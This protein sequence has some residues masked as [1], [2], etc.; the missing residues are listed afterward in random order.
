MA[1]NLDTHNRAL[2]VNLDS[3]VF[4]TV[5]RLYAGLRHGEGEVAAAQPSLG[6]GSP[7]PV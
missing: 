5:A 7:R 2:K 4:G 1:E 3:K 6:R